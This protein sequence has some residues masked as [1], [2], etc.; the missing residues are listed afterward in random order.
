MPF[1]APLIAALG[2]KIGASIAAIKI[3]AI[4]KAT[5]ISVGVSIGSSLIRKLFR[6]QPRRRLNESRSTIA[7]EV[8]A[9]RWV[10]GTRVRT[11][12]VLVYWGSS[13]PTA[14]MGLSTL[15]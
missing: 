9:R 11:P 4:I 10:L 6:K 8:T 3:G 13:G 2:A 1:L 7:S 5:L 15:R 12:G 14:R